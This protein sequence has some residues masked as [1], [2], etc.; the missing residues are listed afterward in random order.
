MAYQPTPQELQQTRQV[1]ADII[2]SRSDIR[3]H[4]KG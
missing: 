3:R 4:F 1:I 2:N